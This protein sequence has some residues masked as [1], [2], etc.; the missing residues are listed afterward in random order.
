MC[1]C[2]IFFFACSTSSS[3]FTCCTFCQTLLTSIS[4]VIS[5]LSTDTFICNY[6]C[7][8]FFACT[9]RSSSFT[10]CTFCQTL[11]TSISRVISSLSTGH[12]YLQLLLH[13]FFCMYY[14]K[15]LLYMWHIL[16]NTSNKHFQSH[17]YHI[18]R[19]RSNVVIYVFWHVVQPLLSCTCLYI[20]FYKNHIG[21]YV[22]HKN[23]LQKDMFVPQLSVAR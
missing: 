2:C 12:I 21:F 3:S 6:Y 23:M 10:C 22:Y 20:L 14:K 1:N 17:K 16:P 13:F 19:H 8:F 9:T 18:H 7:I 15:F 4:R 5:S 11:L